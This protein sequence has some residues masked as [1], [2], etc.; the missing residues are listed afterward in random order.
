MRA[1]V[2]TAKKKPKPAAAPP[3]APSPAPSLF[4]KGDP[5]QHSQF[6]KG[7]VSSVDAGK[8]TIAFELVGTKIVLESYLKRA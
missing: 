7:T 3:V 4:A 6:G 8:L 5:V 1:V 2:K